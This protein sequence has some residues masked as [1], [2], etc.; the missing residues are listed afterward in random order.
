MVSGGARSLVDGRGRR[1]L[2]RGVVLRAPDPVRWRDVLAEEEEDVGRA[3]RRGDLVVLDDGDGA[4]VEEAPPRVVA[5]P[6]LKGKDASEEKKK[7]KTRRG[8]RHVGRVVAELDGPEVVHDR[9]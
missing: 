4:V 6:G 8:A 9:A 7:Q 3:R 2:A 5:R 1:R